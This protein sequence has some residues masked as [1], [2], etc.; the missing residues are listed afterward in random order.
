MTVAPQTLRD[1]HVAIRARME[2]IAPRFAGLQ[3]KSGAKRAPRIYDVG[4][5]PKDGKDDERFPAI[6]VRPRTGTDS[7][8]A[9]DE[10][11]RATVDL[12]IAIYR[13]EED[14]ALDVLAV[15][16]AIRLNIGETPILSGTAFEHVGPLTWEVFEQ[17]ALPSIWEG[18]VTTTWQIPRPQRATT[19]VL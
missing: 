4:L 1:L 6:V 9:G 8:Q 7:A 10:A 15:I 11:S 17:Q 16:D 13:D 5:A 18:R 3:T 2:E 12:I 19:E 14:G